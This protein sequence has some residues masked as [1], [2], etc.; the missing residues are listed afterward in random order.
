MKK[1]CY[2]L[3]NIHHTTVIAYYISVNVHLGY[4]Y[5]KFSTIHSDRSTDI[6]II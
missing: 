3:L 4:D 6:Q 5:L 1:C 2:Y